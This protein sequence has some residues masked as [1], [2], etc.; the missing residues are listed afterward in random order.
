MLKEFKALVDN[1]QAVL[2]TLPND[3]YKHVN[4]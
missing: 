2:P 4:T 3:Y 1:A